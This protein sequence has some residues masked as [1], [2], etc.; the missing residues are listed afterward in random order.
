MRVECFFFALLPFFAFLDFLS[1]LCFFFD[2]LFL[3]FLPCFLR[4]ASASL[5]LV[6]PAAPHRL[7]WYT[8]ILRDAPG[9]NMKWQYFS[10]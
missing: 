6:I 3:A 9:P 2:L 7:P 8:A 4:I 1:S 10:K 5:T